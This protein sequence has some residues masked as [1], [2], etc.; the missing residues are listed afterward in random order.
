MTQKPS[1]QSESVVHAR[2]SHRP[3]RQSNVG[4]HRA[5]PVQVLGWQRLPTQVVPVPQGLVRLHP[6]TQSVSP[7]QPQW[8]GSQIS[9]APH[10]ASLAQPLGWLLQ[11]PQAKRVPGGAQS[12]KLWH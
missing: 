9:V 3:L 4:G 11:I 2:R 7:E 12:S 10:C 8:R 5:E 1:R 6:G